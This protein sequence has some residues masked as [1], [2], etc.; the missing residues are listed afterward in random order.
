MYLKID[1]KTDH[2]Y[3]Y[4]FLDKNDNHLQEDAKFILDIVFNLFL[5]YN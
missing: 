2:K 3:I 4:L 5:T 1:F